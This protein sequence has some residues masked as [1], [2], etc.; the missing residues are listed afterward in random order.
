MSDIEYILPD[1]NKL[2]AGVDEVARGTF[3]GPVI[4]ACVLLPVEFPDENYKQIKDSKKLS[5]KKREFLANYIK[6]NC[7]TYGIGEASCKEI[8]DINILNATMKAMHRAIDIAY[9]KTKFE[10]LVIDGPNFKPYIPPGYDNDIIEYEC[11]PKGD[12]KYLSIAA[13]SILAKDYHTKYI[14]NLV[15]NNDKLLLYDIQKNKG[16]GTKK[17]HEAIKAHGLT[18]FHRK[19]FGICRN[20]SILLG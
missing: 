18:E 4:S 1:K 8:D 17:H 5:E 20:Y 16:Y 11:V 3:I 6:E 19:T 14:K 10:Y 12:S 7:I 9:K 13:A 2:V 15:A